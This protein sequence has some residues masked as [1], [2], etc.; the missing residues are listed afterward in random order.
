MVN[1]V[2][3]K[4]PLRRSLKVMGSSESLLSVLLEGGRIPTCH[5]YFGGI[6]LPYVAHDV[7]LDGHSY[8]IV[9]C[10]ERLRNQGW[11][12]ELSLLYYRELLH[13][14]SDPFEA[15][16]FEDEHWRKHRIDITLTKGSEVVRM[17]VIHMPNLKHSDCQNPMERL[18]ICLQAIHRFRV[19]D[20]SNNR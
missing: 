3:S 6:V 5:L 1:S 14:G 12:S 16:A 8:M 13:Y 7:R 10:V 11:D 4:T 2:N 19:F 20:I 17:Q 15:A 18:K 9:G